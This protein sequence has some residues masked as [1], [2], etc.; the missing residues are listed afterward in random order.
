MPGTYVVRKRSASTLCRTKDQLRMPVKQGQIIHCMLLAIYK[1][2][3]E[4]V[5][6]IGAANEYYFDSEERQRIF[7]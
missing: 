5:S 2:K 6:L 1:E 7:G 3:T 4:N